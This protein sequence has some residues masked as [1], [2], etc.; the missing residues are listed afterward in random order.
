MQA[1]HWSRSWMPME[2]GIWRMQTRMAETI[3]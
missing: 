1:T 3:L 2:N